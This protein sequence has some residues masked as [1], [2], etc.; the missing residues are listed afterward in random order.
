MKKIKIILG[1]LTLI[2]CVNIT[3]KVSAESYK[4][5]GNCG[6]DLKWSLDY[7]GNFVVYGEGDMEDYGFWDHTTKGWK[8]YSSDIKKV[9]VEKGVTSI[10]RSAFEDCENLTTVQLPNT[11]V[12]ID[13]YAFRECTSL[14]KINLPVGLKE[15]GSGTFQECTALEKIEFPKTLTNLGDKG[16][17]L[18]TFQESGL[19]QVVIPSSVTK[20]SSYCFYGCSNLTSVT[21]NGRNLT[22]TFEAFMN[23]PN[24]KTVKIGSGVA[25]IESEAFANCNSLQN[26]TIGSNVNK[27]DHKVFNNCTSL[28]EVVVPDKVERLDYSVFE[29]CRNLEKVT[30]G[31]RVSRIG[32]Y[33]F[34]NCSSLKEIYFC[35]EAPTFEGN[36]TFEGCQNVLAYYPKT[37]KTWDRSTLTSHGAIRTDW[38]TWDIPLGHY[39]PVLNS[40][41]A[42]GNGITI[43]WN[44]LN[45]VSG[46]QVLRKTGNGTWEKVKNISGNSVLTWTDKDVTNGKRYTYQVCGIKVNEISKTSNQKYI[47]YLEKNTLS[48]SR[49]G[50]Y[51]IVKWKKNNSATGYQI[52]YSTLKSFSLFTEYMIKGRSKTSQK[53]NVVGKKDKY[54]RIRTYKTVNGVT[55][56]SAWSNVKIIKSY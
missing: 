3:F 54:I 45:A 11:L 56:Y 9:T 18:S 12:L 27:I 44:K 29:N 8:E 28:R 36:G 1:F 22:I 47:Y 6:R 7:D 42:T 53:F 14:N 48:I 25:N 35:C 19:K 52:R 38:N 43:K 40:L 33:A 15:I 46:Y 32:N 4:A 30:L 26:I 17:G 16:A 39:T 24:L 37:S 13:S 50:S 51:A 41:N 49:D 10:G 34:R 55:S 20:M 5:G 23:C 31:V 2:L 21:V